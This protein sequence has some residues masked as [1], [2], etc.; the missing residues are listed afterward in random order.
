MAII[1]F[2]E[3]LKQSGG[4]SK[5]VKI[6]SQQE[7][8]PEEVGLFSR[9]S[10]NI[11]SAGV[12]VEEA[13][14][15]TGEYAGRSTIGRAVGAAA[16]AFGAI[17]KVGMEVLPKPIRTGFEEVGK[18][19]G[20][21]VNL[22]ADKVSDVKALQDWTIQHPEAARKL[23]DIAGIGKSAGEISGSILAAEAGMKVLSAGVKATGVAAKT[24][25]KTLTDLKGK[26]TP[27]AAGIM[28]RV[29]RV[30][31]GKQASFE[32]LAGENIGTY[33]DRRGIYGNTDKIS[34]ELF[35][36]F[37]TSRREVDKAF[38]S[39]SGKYKNLSVQQALKGL[40]EREGKVSVPGARSKDYFTIKE[41]VNKYNKDGLT[42]SE[43]NS[44]KRLYER[45]VRLDYVKQNLPESVAR[46]TNID[47]ALRT[48][49]F[50][51][52]A[53]LGLKN[54]KQLNKETQLAKQLL[55]DIGKEAGG[56]AGNNMIT[57]TDWIVL[58]GGDPTA[59]S[60]FLVKKGLSMKKT[61]S[62]IAKK[63]STSEKV[64]MPKSEFGAPKKGFLDLNQ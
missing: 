7:Q 53:K 16:E 26:I 35:K 50:E 57:L 43:I 34:E 37:S 5:D 47:N 9:I 11:K 23:E 42:M 46:A 30:S 59:I 48:W 21:A 39:L 61:Q 49:Q 58:A 38:A 4:T 33:L 22:L 54:I 32:K 10:Q 29:A 20:G 60:L 6:V 18:V 17:P 25:A 27:D 56:I 14:S 64:P 12:G 44:V 3:F 55:D 63:I 19:V 51:Q 13:I 31:K 8:Q 2:D 28:Q 24:T 41:L 36:R 62:W 45:N 15:G 1:S 40:L 52:A